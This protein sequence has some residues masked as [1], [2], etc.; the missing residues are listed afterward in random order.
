MTFREIQGT[1]GRFFAIFAII[2]LGVGFFSGIRMTTPVI[3]HTVDTFYKEYGFYDYHLLSTLGW[4]EEDVRELRGEEDAV[5]A[6]GAWQYDV[7]CENKDGEFAVYKVYSIT[8][9]VNRL[10]LMEGEMPRNARECIVDSNN[11]MS[12]KV[13][14]TIRFSELNEE[15]TLKAFSGTEF[16]VAGFADSSLYIN[17]ERGTTSIGNGAVRGF[18]YLP[19]E[20]FTEDYYTDVYVRL[21]GGDV[22]FSDA[23]SERMD[24]NRDRWEMAAQDAADGRFERLYTDAEKEISDA[25]D[26]FEEKKADGEKEL[27]DAEK[28]LEDGK[29]ELDDAEKELA[30]GKKELDDAEKE[31]KENKE[32]LDDAADQL[33]DGK[34]ELD[35]AKSKLDSG[36]KTLDASG[37]EIEEGQKK[38][39]ETDRQLKEAKSELDE[40]EK[41]LAES[42]KELDA[43][44]AELDEN[45]KKLDAAKATL[46]ESEKELSGAKATLD[47]TEKQ[48]TDAKQQLDATGQQLDAAKATLDEKGKELE[49]AKAVL[50][51]TEKELAAAKETLDASGKELEA[52]KTVLDDKGNELAAAKAALDASEKE[53]AAVKAELDASEGKLAAAKAQLDAMKAMLA[54][55]ST[56]TDEESI[57]RYHALLAQYEAAKSQYD[58]GKARYDA[59]KAQ[60]DAGK[61]QY[62]A[63]KAQYDAG[64][65]EYDAGKAQY[66]TGVAQ[67][68]AGKAQYEAGKAQYEAG[69]AQYED[70]MAQYDA[71]VAEYEAGKQ[72]YEAGVAQYESGKAQY[73]AGKAQYEAGKAQYDAGKAEYETGRSQFEEGKAQYE[74]GKAQYDAGKKQFDEGKSQYEAG[75]KQYEEAAAQFE[76][77]KRQYEQGVAEYERGLA[78]YRSGKSQYDDNLKKYQDG[79][80]EFEEGQQKFEDA[81]VEYDEG[82]LEYEDGLR[83]Y[84]D[85]LRDYEEGKETFDREIVDA[86]TKLSDAEAELADLKEPDTYVLERN[87]NIAY[88]CFESDSEIVAQ[89]AKV[90]PVFFILVAVL[91]CMT[92]MTRMAEE[93]RGQIGVLKGLGYSENDIIRTFMVYSGSAAVLGCVFGFSAGIF[94][95]PAVIWHAYKIMYIKLPLLWIFSWKLAL[96]VLLVSILCS[97]GTTYMSIRS[98]LKEPAASLLRPRAPKAGKR[99]FLEYIPFIWSRMKFMHKISARNI[100]RYKKRFFMMVIGISG[101]TALLLTGFGINDSIASFAETQYGEIQVADADLVFKEGKGGELPED[102]AEKLLETGASYMPYHGSTWDLLAGSQVK[103]VNLIAPYDTEQ[104]DSFFRLRDT[105]G[106]E[107]ALPAEGE[108][109]ISVSIAERYHLSAG[110]TMRLRNEDMK[111]MTVR[112]TGIFENHVYNYV[113]LTPETIAGVTGEADANGA[114]VNFAEGEDVYQAQTALAAC[115]NV[116]T[117]M[118]FKDFMVRLTKMMSSLNLIVIV[119]ILSAAGLALVVLYNLTNINILERIREI[120]TIK[121]LGFYRNETAEYVFRENMVL[122]LFGVIAGLGLGILLHR[123][124]IKQ[125]VVDMVYFNITIRPLS[126]LWSVLLTF[127][128]TLLVNQFMSFRIDKINMAESLKSV[129]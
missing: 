108:A 96:A 31:L 68:E 87:T 94:L 62:D 6:E 12:L 14:D 93:Q 34:R 124:V 56:K 7:I 35:E 121:V 53:L 51:A 81:K 109:L 123:F 76:A 11:R 64:K 70:G 120:A 95:F 8:D 29:K 60:Y 84:K 82:V 71:G 57:A 16:K 23:Y 22:I 24:E 99:I 78:E 129:E 92:T 17:F 4:E 103:S 61:A 91:V 75:K 66:E 104:L 10:R 36:K 67:Y 9:D 88:S 65:A 122:T 28:E 105:D 49:S 77:G 116:T 69:K 113:I 43:G 32:K 44:K 118:L 110:D 19:K 54:D 90:F 20:A 114:Y 26:E 85:G 1:F 55:L 100:F 79:R 47:E 73:D 74:T 33:A 52:A 42:E 38:L 98:E 30:D 45:E 102:V 48:L 15:D 101:C 50:D 89:I 59:G 126:F 86:E 58:A 119:V 21:N 5:C 3:V 127:A 111:S 83:K 18:L 117:V 46:D 112:V 40:N 37:K 39:D 41:I 128:F 2:A 107:L 80:R 97:A 25:R 13:G 63:G 27:A 115:D 106:G 72:Q 125:I